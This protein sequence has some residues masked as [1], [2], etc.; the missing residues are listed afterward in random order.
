[1]RRPEYWVVFVEFWGE[2]LHDRRLR[3][4]NTAVY[5][6]ARRLLARLIADGVRSGRFRAVDPTAAA[7]VVLGL[8]DGL[9][10]QLTF[11][12]GAF[13]VA[14]AT[15]FCAEALDHYLGREASS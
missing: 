11:D 3:D 6:R 2:M 7:A 15:R 13:S 4:L 5:T 14:V 1:M 10:L 12:P 8:V 9:S